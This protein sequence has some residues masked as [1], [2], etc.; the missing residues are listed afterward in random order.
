MRRPLP[1][2]LAGAVFVLTG[3]AFAP[4]WPGAPTPAPPGARWDSVEQSLGSPDALVTVIAYL[5]FGCPHCAASARR[6]QPWLVERYVRNGEVRLVYQPAPFLGEASVRAHA[7]A[8]CV[9]EQGPEP[10]WCYYD[11]LFALEGRLPWW[12]SE[13]TFLRLAA[14]AGADPWALDECLKSGRYVEAMRWAKAL[15]SQEGVSGTPTL[16]IGSETLV[17]VPSVDTLGDKLEVA[18]QS[19]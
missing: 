5:D 12:A 9:A 18:L 14:E 1:W 10:F 6:V 2:F 8:A 3:A 17:G 16:R 13:R 7:A 11:R 15:A 4:F 19:R